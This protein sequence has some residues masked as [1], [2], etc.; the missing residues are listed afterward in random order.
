MLQWQHIHGVPYSHIV[1]CILPIS[2]YSLSSTGLCAVTA[3]VKQTLNMPRC[4]EALF[5]VRHFLLR[6]FLIAHSRSR[7]INRKAVKPIAIPYKA[8]FGSLTG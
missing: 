1:K 2:T 8:N 5:A 3:Q 7:S 6:C 4:C